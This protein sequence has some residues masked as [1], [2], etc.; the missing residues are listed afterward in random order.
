MPLSECMEEDVTITPFEYFGQI[1]VTSR[2][3][4]PADVSAMPHD[5]IVHGSNNLN[6]LLSGKTSMKLFEAQ[7]KKA[8]EVKAQGIVVHI[9]NAPIEKV[10]G[11]V[12]KMKSPVPIILENNSAKSRPGETYE[13]PER[14]NALVAALEDCKNEWCLCID[15]AH[16]WTSLND[17]RYPIETCDGFMRWVNDL[18]P[19]TVAR[20][21]YWH[22]NGSINPRGRGKDQHAIPI[23]G[24][25]DRPDLMWGHFK[26]LKK[27]SIYP[28]LLWAKKYNTPLICEMNHCDYATLEKSLNMI[29]ELAAKC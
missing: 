11:L 18:S 5:Y 19:A 29:S 20:L 13:T 17:P 12:N 21:K 16:L 24:M 4:K 9:P 10:V 15:T 27:S 22:F 1:N 25:N 28:L 23:L 26:D 8:A 3:G 2:F 7:A 6:G 14:L